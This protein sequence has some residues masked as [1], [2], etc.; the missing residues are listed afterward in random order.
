MR[1]DPFS[2]GGILDSINDV[3]RKSKHNGFEVESIKQSLLD[4]E[5][6][7]HRGPTGLVEED[8]DVHME[9]YIPENT[10]STAGDDVEMRDVQTDTPKKQQPQHSK[11]MPIG[12]E[13]SQ[14]ST[15]R[16]VK[17]YLLS[18]TELGARMAVGEEKGLV[19]F[20]DGKNSIDGD[21]LAQTHTPETEPQHD[22]K[23]SGQSELTTDPSL[24][25]NTQKLP[26]E[27]ASL[28][29]SGTNTKSANIPYLLSTSLQLLFNVSLALIA[30]YVTSSTIIAFWRDV[31]RQIETYSNE[32]LVD[33]SQCTRLYLENDC[34]P[35]IRPPA[36]HEECTRL[37]KC[38]DMD[39]G[40]IR[41][42]KVAAETLAEIIDSFVS[43]FS[44]KTIMVFGLAFIGACYTANV[45]FGF[46]RAKAYYHQHNNE[47]TREYPSTFAP[48][49][50][51]QNVPGNQPASGLAS[52]SNAF[53]TDP[54]E[55][56]PYA[57][58]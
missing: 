49:G 30:L 36:L 52:G 7:S 38:M 54:I 45:M 17:N 9:D 3:E 15:P 13:G 4:V 22:E 26:Q 53:L 58:Q 25:Q 32:L 27:T 28:T 47:R 41:R 14:T 10:N 56:S 55:R 2:V 33:I 8:D 1:D 44:Y 50:N 29:E 51:Y 37:E 40:S 12:G 42:M 24:S 21:E 43:T 48:L 18:P 31:D 11:S 20:E 39:T 6:N 34:R 23:P 19:L 5:Q 35:D 16:R 57:L 46:A